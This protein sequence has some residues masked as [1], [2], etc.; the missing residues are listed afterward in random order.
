MAV[1]GLYLLLLNVTHALL[2]PSLADRFLLSLSTYTRAYKNL[3]VIPIDQGMQGIIDAY[4]ELDASWRAYEPVLRKTDSAKA[5]AMEARVAM[6]LFGNMAVLYDPE[7]PDEENMF[8]TADVRKAYERISPEYLNQLEAQLRPKYPNVNL[9][10]G[11]QWIFPMDKPLL[12][13]DAISNAL[14][15]AVELHTGIRLP[16]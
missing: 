14:L 1:F 2:Q 6:M 9:T 12:L 4:G 7:A 8:T 10:W 13:A 5:D 3:D 15:D 16:K 11:D